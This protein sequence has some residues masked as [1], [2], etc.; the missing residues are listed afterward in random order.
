VSG[1]ELFEPL[2]LSVPKR[3]VPVAPENE[4]RLTAQSAGARFH[5]S[6]VLAAVKDLSG[7]ESRRDLRTFVFPESLT[8]LS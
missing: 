6:Q 2:P 1:K 8:C 3:I 4:G 7:E 5:F